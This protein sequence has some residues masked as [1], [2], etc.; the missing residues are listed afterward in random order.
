MERHLKVDFGASRRTTSALPVVSTF[1]N[2]LYSAPEKS[3]LPVTAKI[4]AKAS[5]R[6]M[7]SE[8]RLV[9][10]LIVVIVLDFAVI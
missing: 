9:L 7:S 4:A 1:L 2:L 10:I 6:V 5:K 8:E 3:V